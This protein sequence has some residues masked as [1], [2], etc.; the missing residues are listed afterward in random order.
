[1]NF[2]SKN[3]FIYLPNILELDDEFRKRAE[4]FT[5]SSE[6]GIVSILAGSI[7]VLSCHLACC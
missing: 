5:D 7:S 2:R 6:E 4:L 1:M 3:V